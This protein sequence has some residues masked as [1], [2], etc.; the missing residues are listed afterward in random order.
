MADSNILDIPQIEPFQFSSDGAGVDNSV[1]L[2]RGDAN[3]CIPLVLLTGRNGL[4]MQISALYRSHVHENVKQRNLTSPTSTLGLGWELPVDRI[5]VDAPGT[6]EHDKKF[7]FVHNEIRNRLYRNNR[8]WLRGV[9]ESYHMEDLNS[10]TFSHSLFASLL[11]QGLRIDVSSEITVLVAGRNW[12]IKD[13]INEFTLDLFF[14]EEDN[15]IHVYDGGRSYEL[16][17][18]DYSRISYYAE[19]EKWAITSTN[20]VT[21]VYGGK[22]SLSEGMKTSENHTVE[23]GVCIGNW[24]GPS[25]VTHSQD[26]PSVRIQSQFAKAWNFAYAYTPWNDKVIFEYDQVMQPVGDNGL[27]Y[28]KAIYLVRAIDVFGRTV[29]LSYKDKVYDATSPLSPREYADPNK[30]EPDDTPDA[31]QSCYQT[32]YLDNI[33]VFSEKEELVYKLSFHY[34]LQRFTEVPSGNSCLYGDTFKRVLVSMTKQLA[35][36]SSFPDVK[37]SYNDISSPCSGSLKSITYPEGSTVT[38]FYAG[39]ELINCSRDLTIPNPVSGSIPNVWFGDDYAVVTWYNEGYLDMTVYS[40][41]GRWQRWVPQISSI[42][43][44]VDLETFSCTIEQDY[45]VLHYKKQQGD[46]FAVRA[47]HKNS[48]IVGA[49]I[50]NEENPLLF[51]TSEITVASGDNYF[52]V[53]DLKNN[54]PNV[55][56]WNLLMNVW[57]KTEL[58]GYVPP[59][60]FSRSRLFLSGI[61]NV[62]LILLYDKAGRP[63]YKNNSLTLYY[64][65]ENGEW[66]LGDSMVDEEIYIEQNDLTAHFNWT[67]LPWAITATYITEVSPSEFRYNLSIYQWTPGYKFKTVVTASLSLQKSGTQITVPYVAQCTPQGLIASGP[68]LL[69]YNGDKWLENENMKLQLPVTDETIFWFTAGPDYVIKTENSESRTLGMVQVFDPN[70]QLY[71]WKEKAVTLYDSVSEEDRSGYFSTASNDFLTWG[72]DIYGRGASTDWKK[73]LQDPAYSIPMGSDTTTLIN[74]SPLFM[75][76]LLKDDDKKEILGTQVLTLKNGIIESS[77]DIRERYFSLINSDRT[78]VGRS[79]GKQP[80]GPGAFLTYLPLENEFDKASSITLHRFIGES[81]EKPIVHHPVIKVSVFDGFQTVDTHYDFDINSAVCDYVGAIAKYY[82]VTVSKGNNR[83][84]GYSDYYFYNSLNGIKPNSKNLTDSSFLDGT[85]SLKQVF[86]ADN[87]LVASTETDFEVITAIAG[88]P[89]GKADTPI[90]GALVLAVQSKES[91]DGVEKVTTYD[92]DLFGGKLR[93]QQVDSYNALGQEEIHKKITV[94]GYEKYESLLYLNDLSSVVQ[95]KELINTDNRG[96]VMVSCTDTTLRLYPV[97]IADAQLL[98]PFAF[99]TYVWSGG[100]DMPENKVKTSVIDLVSDKGIVLEKQAP[101]GKTVSKLYNI[102]QS[103]VVA[104]FSNAS[105][106]KDEAYYYGFETYEDPGRWVIDARTPITDRGSYSGLRCLSILPGQRGEA[107]VLSPANQNR[108]YIFTCWVKGDSET[109]HKAGWIIELYNQDILVKTLSMDFPASDK[110]QFCFQ[111]IPFVDWMDQLSVKIIPFNEGN[112]TVY[113]DNV[114]FTPFDN[115]YH[116]FVYDP[117]YHHVTEEIGPFDAVIRYRYDSYGRMIGHTGNSDNLIKIISPYLSRQTD[118]SFDIS[119]PNAL[120]SFQPMGVTFIDRFHNNG[121]LQENWAATEPLHWLSDQGCIV[122]QGDSSDELKF[123]D[124]LFTENYVAHIGLT[125]SNEI[126]S[127]LGIKVGDGLAIKWSKSSW[128]LSD[129]R[130]NEERIFN[131]RNETPGK[132]WILALSKE[133]VFFWVDGRLIF[134]YQ[135][136]QM[137]SGEFTLCASGKVYFSNF[138]IGTKP[139]IAIQYM[140]GAGKKRQSQSLEG[141]CV[142]VVQSVYNTASILEISTM[143]ATLSAN[144][145]LLLAYRADAVT[146]FDRTSGLLEGSIADQLPDAEGYPYSRKLFEHSPLGRVIEIG[147]PG[148][149][150]AIV[151]GQNNHTVKYTYGKNTENDFSLPVGQY[152]KTLRC[153]QNGNISYILLDKSGNQVYS[154]IPMSNEKSIITSVVMSYNET[155]CIK[156]ERLPNYFNPPVGSKPED[157]QRISLFD[158]RGRLIA[159]TEANSATSL[160]IYDQNGALRF[161]QNVVQADKG[162]LLYKKYDSE[163]RMIEEGFLKASWEQTFLQ[164]QADTNPDWPGIADGA[165]PKRKYYFNGDGC[166]L[167]DLGNLT[168]VEIMNSNEPGQVESHIRRYY[169]SNQ[170]VSRVDVTLLEENKVLTTCYGYDNLGNAQSIRYPSGIELTNIR[171]EVG[172]VAK[173]MGP[174]EKEMMELLYTPGDQIAVEIN[175]ITADKPQITKYT[176]NQQGWLLRAEGPYLTEELSY[177][178]GGWGGTAVY[179]NGI[180]ASKTISRH[181]PENE[182]VSELTYRYC[183]DEAYRIKTAAC[184]LSGEMKKEWS[185]GLNEPVIYDSNGNFLQVNEDNYVYESGTD[186]VLN[187]K[188]SSAQDYTYDKNGATISAEPRGITA[189]LRDFYSGKPISIETESKG[190]LKF[191]YDGNNNRLAKRSESYVKYYGRNSVGSVLTEQQLDGQMM[192]ITDFL[193]GPNG[194][195]GIISNGNYYAIRTDNLKSPL[196]L[197][198]ASG[199]VVSAYQYDPFGSLVDSKGCNTD[200]LSYLFGGYELDRETGLYSSNSRLYDPVLKR[201]YCI[202]PQMQ[203]ASPYIF[204][205]NNPMNLVDPNG[206]SSWWAILIGAVVGTI[207]TIATAGAGA[208]LAAIGAATETAAVAGTATAVGV[209]SSTTADVISATSGIVGG[210][211]GS[212][213][214]DAT[215]AGISGEA[216]TPKMA[217]IGVLTGVVGG[218]VGAGVSAGVEAGV[219]AIVKSTAKTMEKTTLYAVQKTASMTTARIAGGIVASGT[220]AAVSG[221]PFFSKEGLINMAVGAVG[222]AGGALIA[223]GANFGWYG[224]TATSKTVMKAFAE[225]TYVAVPEGSD[226]NDMASVD[227]MNT[228]GIVKEESNAAHGVGRSVIPYSS[229][230]FAQPV[231][232]KTFSEYGLRDIQSPNG[233]IVPLKLPVCF[234]SVTDAGKVGQNLGA[235]LGKNEYSSLWPIYS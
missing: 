49:W 159:F 200:L 169:D 69:R 142:T 156:T 47:F 62:L 48:R 206:E 152:F 74:Q 177:I 107:I 131:N 217:G 29:V 165:I 78:Y 208:A 214:G 213:V 140:D 134:S 183:Y 202:D 37:F 32:K 203:F 21:C 164:V 9:L 227:N 187:T 201:F 17:G 22:V 212:I 223:S 130:N 191:I 53:A 181:L 28:T 126:K 114:G 139:Q 10:H 225:Q 184:S 79:E 40:W 100:S 67:P 18:Y 33:E 199:K 232:A 162:Y 115:P 166:T 5:E 20:G 228:I 38:Y 204:S 7:Y 3:F 55:Y 96:D 125:N 129:S 161:S 117:L 44:Y 151:G 103:A 124:P 195:F 137:V 197:T 83:E 119:E 71:D 41:I 4:D 141:K 158:T 121:I 153:D 76:Y 180:V 14:T 92:Y 88:Q 42:N 19:F 226:N 97:A 230:G 63:K 116:A 205:G 56:T 105:I 13:T 86:D 154:V 23:W 94:Y 84:N 234:G 178:H 120:L 132:E 135:P 51:S 189:I 39:K 73:P 82:K 16:Q 60:I 231:S 59:S 210:T 89:G 31:F 150:F 138:F 147:A 186:R 66:M 77:V 61:N 209:I 160:F 176:Y 207:V 172:R 188:G 194:L 182:T 143:P 11:S 111:T 216:Y 157:W 215:T 81:L 64:L 98:L 211:I 224:K 102:D 155:G 148:K 6:G 24:Q 235:A 58:P 109:C 222:A 221:E 87:K 52:V 219:G 133:A 12:L 72:T 43:D 145:H 45:F 30:A 75:V 112:E 8:R 54:Q 91:K 168:L 170:Q 99:E 192:N 233:A 128:S 167:N 15:S 127:G 193:Y 229:K 95:S 65:D 80:G 123:V 106:E 144:D 118:D 101:V 2:F 57:K 218:L 220:G 68:H 35:G 122:H 113:C 171:D 173:I 146:S 190:I 104:S 110:W 174:G 34:D 1:N 50:E 90:Y 85:L 27:S 198:D 185:L 149:D 163:N 36:S 70:T 175:K 196:L 25:K 46:I 108:N 93:G 136:K 26:D 179:Y